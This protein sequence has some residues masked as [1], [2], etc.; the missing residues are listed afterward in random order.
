MTKAIRLRLSERTMRR[1]GPAVSAAAPAG[2]RASIPDRSRRSSA[3]LRLQREY[4]NRYVG[5]LLQ[6]MRDGASA[7]G[8]GTALQRQP[9]P[10]AACPTV[11]SLNF[12]DPLHVPHC[13]GPAPRATADVRGV[14]WSLEPDTARVDPGSRITANGT[15]T[16]AATQ[17]TGTIKARATGAGGCFAEL[18]FDIRSHPVG[19][20]STRLVSAAGG[21]QFGGTFDHIFDSANGNVAS[22]DGV[23][24]GERFTNVPNPPAAVHALVAPLFPFGGTFT[25]HTATLTPTAASGSNWFLTPAGGLGG[26]LDSVTID[27]AGINVGR[28]VQSAS[29]PSPPHGLPGG[30][31]LFQSLHWFCPQRPAANRW[32][33][34]ITV[35]HTRTLRNVGGV[36][37]FA[38]AVNGV[39]QID[40]Y[41][42]PTAVFNLNAKPA[43][44]PRSRPAA[45]TPGATLPSPRT[46]RLRA[47][48][49]PANLPAGQ[50]LAWSIVGAAHGCS[51]SPDPADT[52]AA[53]LAIG[54]TAGTVTVQAA[55]P[56]GVNRARVAVVVT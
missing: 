7:A 20:A 6:R 3:L 26:T 22:L 35:A 43:S 48:T 21:T 37:E 40:A 55:D 9:V 28:F 39:E 54:R 46:V 10:P 18:S 11:V 52:H 51:V 13:G 32:I 5:K 29:N 45:A 50:A 36:L 30:F 12:S 31:T 56:T 1:C 23:P 4:G 2:A 34:F 41:G 49:L 15:I 27:Q 8:G 38:T 14:T 44:T 47:D 24:V 42:G 25:F 19:I 33:A 16:L 53:I 17:P